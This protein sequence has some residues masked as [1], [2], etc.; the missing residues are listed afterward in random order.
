MMDI[1][2]KGIP[3]KVN[4]GWGIKGFRYI[5][6]VEQRKRLFKRFSSIRFWCLL[7]K[8]DFM[9]GRYIGVLV[10]NKSEK[11]RDDMKLELFWMI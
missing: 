3:W 4:E 10:I 5:L 1:L 7:T 9:G 6:Y 2:S 8:R 11:V